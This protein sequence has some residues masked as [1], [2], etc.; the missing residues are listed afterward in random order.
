MAS[1]NKQTL[2][3]QYGRLFLQKENQKINTHEMVVHAMVNFHLIKKRVHLYI[4]TFSNQKACGF[5]PRAPEAPRAR[6]F[7][8]VFTQ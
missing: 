5:V 8:D 7:N 3:H 4:V 2:L 6:P 1:L